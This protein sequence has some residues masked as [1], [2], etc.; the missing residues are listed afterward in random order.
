MN[1]SFQTYLRVREKEGR[2]YPDDIVRQLPAIAADHPLHREWQARAAS[3]NRL[4]TYL[5]QF[6]R[7]STVLELGCGNG[8]LANNIAGAGVSVVGLDGNWI[9]LR[10]AQRLF[11][12]RLE[13]SWIVTDIFS[14][15]FGGSTFD[16]VVIASAIQ[17]FA[18]LG[19][20]LETLVPLLTTGGEIHILDSPLYQPQ[21]L[22]AARD[23]SRK[24]YEELGVPEMA[25]YYYHHSSSGLSTYN[26]EY[27][28]IPPRE[29][30]RGTLQDSPFPWICL[31]PDC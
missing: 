22:P 21:D 1:D 2:L 14:A 25:D 28:Y 3:C 13:M 17:Y 27:L 15:P 9:E 6:R 26:P 20:L 8:W 4:T 11:G 12:N 24:Y 18:D 19:Q 7:H 29:R 23:R 31:R 10:Q 30:N 16:V 5:S